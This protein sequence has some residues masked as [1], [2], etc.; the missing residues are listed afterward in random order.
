MEKNT[1]EYAKIGL[2][3]IIAVFM[4]INTFTG[5]GGSSDIDKAKFANPQANQMNQQGNPNNPFGQDG[6]EIKL[7]NSQ[8]NPMN[9]MNDVP[10]GPKTSMQFAEMEH[11]FGNIK[12]DSENK[13]VFKFTNTGDEPLIINGAQGSCGCT[14]PSYPKEPIA[15]G[16]QGDI[17]VVYSPGKQE[18]QQQKTVTITANTEPATTVL[19][20][21]AFVEPG[22]GN[23][24]AVPG[25]H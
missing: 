17:E 18:N 23:A 20:I 10:T 9:Q 4:G 2:L 25:G 1:L 15:P 6:Q 21:S 24:D 16:E 13:Y 11:D 12:Q 22:T 5:G 19:K 14:V 3:A 8:M 7:D